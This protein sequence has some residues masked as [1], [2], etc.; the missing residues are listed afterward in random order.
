MTIPFKNKSHRLTLEIQSKTTCRV[1]YVTL[2][3]KNRFIVNKTVGKLVLKFRVM[4]TKI[5]DETRVINVVTALNVK[6]TQ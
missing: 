5:A 2:S 6:T 4:P 1:R 3:F